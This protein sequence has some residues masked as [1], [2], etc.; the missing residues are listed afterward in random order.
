MEPVVV[1]GALKVLGKVFSVGLAAYKIRRDWSLSVQ[2]IEQLESF[3]SGSSELVGMLKAGGGASPRMFALHTAL[4]MRAFGTACQEHWAGD[5]AMAPGL[6]SPSWL[7]RRFL[8]KSEKERRSDID[9]RLRR[10][11]DRLAGADE[12]GPGKTF[13]ALS[14]MVAAPLSSPCYQSLWEAFTNPQLEDEEW[15]QARL[16]ELDDPGARLEF[17][18]A[19]RLAYAEAIISPGGA[20]VARSMVEIEAA[21]PQFLRELIVRGLSTWKRQHVFGEVETPGVPNMP[22][23]D[24]YVEP[25]GIYLAQKGGEKIERREPVK[26]LVHDLLRE[27]KIVIVRG[28][29]GHGKS[30]TARSLAC[31]WAETYLTAQ[32]I[33]SPDLVYP[34]FIKCGVDFANHEPSLAKVVPRAFRNQ[35]QALKISLTADDSALVRPAGNEQVVYIVDGLDEVALTPAEVDELFKDLD[36]NTTDRHRAIVFSRKG[37]VPQ[38]ENLRGIPVVDVQHL[39]TKGPAEGRGGQVAEWL[40]RWNRLSGKS[41][42]NI[43][44]IEEKRLMDV[45]TTPIILFMAA[46]T[47]DAQQKDGTPLDKAEIYERFFRQIAAGKCQQDQDQHL[48]VIEASR[49]LLASLV[50]LKEVDPPRADGVEPAARA[51]AMLWLMARIAWEGQRCAR[52]GDDLTLHEVTA[53]LRDELNI[54]SDPKA[55]EMIRIG[56]LLVLQADH[57]GGN[58]RILFGHKSFREFLVARYWASQLRRIVAA[59]HDRRGTIEKKLLGAR[60]LGEDDGTLDF[61]LQILNGPAWDDQEREKLVE[62]A[63]DQFNDE[64]PEFAEAAAP[65]WPADMRPVFREAA[66]AI[67]SSLKGSEGL[68]SANPSTLRTMLGWFWVVRMRSIVVAPRLSS[69]SASLEEANLVD[70]DLRGARLEGASLPG[71]SLEGAILLSANLQ[72]AI[73]LSANLRGA[74]LQGANL[75]HADLEGASLE[76]ADLRGANLEHAYLLGARLRRAN[77]RGANLEGAHL[78]GANLQGANLQGANLQGANPR[79][80]IFDSDTTWPEGFEIARVGSLEAKGPGSK[81]TT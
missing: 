41:P 68:S 80:A 21:R 11:L 8:T 56:V 72:G 57:H 74:N 65:A 40:E 49:R 60:L 50:T 25:D 13:N 78:Q 62:W 12:G 26:Q 2:E 73:L 67:G 61:L 75:E 39:R 45:V 22:L 77:L 43:Q 29:F 69:G 71:A 19:Y 36:D 1:A 16:L 70:A 17:E 27:H 6:A 3:V 79:D 54:R 81:P 23:A 55:E 47:W 7:R 14:A 24:I 31:E 18:R 38:R 5:L 51:L 46:L 33:S 15:T 4:V 64:T 53:I 52:R 63:N 28:D 20:E 66:L 48:P 42:I 10:A 76:H 30:L 37:V 35:A 44:Q 32:T 9:T 34:V 58:D 59:R